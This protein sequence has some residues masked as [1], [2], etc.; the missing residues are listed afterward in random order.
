M[1]VAIRVVRIMT[2]TGRFLKL[3]C[4]CFFNTCDFN[5]KWHR[6]TAKLRSHSWEYDTASI[7]HG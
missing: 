2:Q 7:A 5:V 1:K 3:E 6:L 4:M